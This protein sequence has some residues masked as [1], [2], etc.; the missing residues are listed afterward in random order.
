MNPGKRAR[1]RWEVALFSSIM[2][3]IGV[4]IVSEIGHMRLQTGYNLAVKEMHASA[5]LGELLGDLTD[6]ETAQRGFLLTRRDNY[7]E[8]YRTA[9]PNMTRAQAELRNYFQETADPASQKEFDATVA[10][11]GQKVSEMELTI[12]L[13]REG[14]PDTA[15]EITRSDIG[16]EKMDL[17]RAK[18][19]GLQQRENERTARLIG[20]WEFNR[21]LSRFSVALVSVLNIVLL[22]LLFRWLGRDWETEKRKQQT[23][24]DEQERLDRLVQQRTSQLDT[25]AT[26]IQQVSENEKTLIARELHDELGAI[27]TASKMDVAWVRQHL[28]AEQGVL[29]DKLVRALKNLDQAVQAKRRIVENLR[30]TTLTTL[31]LVVALHDYAEQVAE[32]NG[33]QLVL[34]LPDEDW[35]LPDDMAIALF[36]ICQESLTNAA[37]YAGATQLVIRLGQSEG[38]VRLSIEDNGRGFVAADARPKSHG[39]AGMRQRMLGLGGSLDVR[40]RTGRGT[41]VHARLPLPVQASAEAPAPTGEELVS[42]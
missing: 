8:A 37:K 25:L 31:G 35:K 24:L 1:W 12:S 29:A 7:L 4:L 15:Q 39:L 3:C 6:A 13:V 17:I 2:I 28:T 11:I 16:K 20:T 42:S 23:L 30:P 38:N 41:S 33:W 27:L 34:D 32:Q 26:H 36:R 40:S 5:R 18:V 22:I 21:N 9:L 14:R 10:L 19:V